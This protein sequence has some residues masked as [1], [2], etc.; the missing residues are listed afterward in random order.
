MQILHVIPNFA[1]AWRLGGPIHAAVELTQEQAQQ[2]HQVTVITT[3]GDIDGVVDVP[4]KR[5]V[6]MGNVSVWYL[7]FLGSNRFA[8]SPAMSRVLREQV[9]RFEI[10]HIHTLFSWASTVGAFWAHRRRV[11]YIIRPAGELDPISLA[12]PY[13]R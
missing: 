6:A 5:P 1:P 9:S 3:N 7:P 13:D 2:G 8:V 12:K 10:V 4:L 11:P